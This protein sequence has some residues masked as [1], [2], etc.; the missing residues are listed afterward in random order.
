MSYLHIL[1]VSVLIAMI[2]VS[3]IMLFTFMAIEKLIAIASFI[4]G[5]DEENDNLE[6]VG[7]SDGSIK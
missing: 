4:F 2:I 3:T 5:E 6:D 1:I 7:R